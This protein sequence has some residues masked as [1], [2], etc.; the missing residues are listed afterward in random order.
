VYNEVDRE[1]EA[2]D[3]ASMAKTWVWSRHFLANK[4]GDGEWIM[5]GDVPEPIVMFVNLITFVR[6]RSLKA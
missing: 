4:N 3:A 5:E 2:L 6:A 1:Y